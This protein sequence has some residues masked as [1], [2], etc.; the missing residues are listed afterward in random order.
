MTGSDKQRAF[1]H[2]SRMAEHR[3]YHLR[4]AVWL[5][6]C[7]VGAASALC[8]WR[9]TDIGRFYVGTAIHYGWPWA[10]GS[11]SDR[12]SFMLNKP[13]DIAR[14]FSLPAAI[15]NLAVLL[16]ILSCTAVVVQRFV[17]QRGRIRLAGIFAFTSV[18]ACLTVFL[19]H[20]Q[21]FYFVHGLPPVGFDYV[22]LACYPWHVRLPI[23]FGLGC[24]IYTAGWLVAHLT[25]KLRRACRR[26]ADCPPLRPGVRRS[27][28]WIPPASC[29]NGDD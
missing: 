24:T 27:L 8:H 16:V 18:I 2:D 23:L 26:A 20:E 10:S 19:Q 4:W 17:R 22:S 7:A 11:Y 28:P 12:W 1:L 29:G 25:G 14:A 3:W 9:G 15:A 5:I 21:K 6:V 13:V